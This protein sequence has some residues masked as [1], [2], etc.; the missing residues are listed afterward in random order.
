[1]KNDCILVWP[2]FHAPYQHRDAISFLKAV[3]AKY[4]PTR[5]I[6]LGD[7]CDLHSVSMHDHDPDLPSPGDELEMIKRALKQLYT[8]FPQVDVLESNHGSLFYRR[9]KKFGLPKKVMKTYQEILEAPNGWRWHHDLTITLP[10]GSPLY[11]CHGQSSDVLKNSK[12]KSMHYIQGHHHS[13][14]E[15][16]YWANSLQLYWGVT[17]G[18]LIDHKAMAFDYGKLALEKPILGC[19]IIK[20]SHPILVPMILDK[21]G[22]WIKRLA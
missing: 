22:R 15:I 3:K 16:R 14:Y 20:N 5:V 17:G 12:N 11:L 1:L 6:S 4:K 8:L 13:K 7:E 18:C 19:T 2:D 9:A 10:D 21:R